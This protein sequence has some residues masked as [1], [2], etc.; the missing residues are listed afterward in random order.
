MDGLPA[1][2]SSRTAYGA[3]SERR[4]L[5]EERLSAPGQLHRPVAALPGSNARLRDYQAAEGARRG[6]LR[7]RG[8]RESE[9]DGGAPPQISVSGSKSRSPG[10]VSVPASTW[11]CRKRV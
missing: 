11:T 8:G 1:R 5:R 7:N 10:Q 6:S 2:P 3:E 9:F 4:D